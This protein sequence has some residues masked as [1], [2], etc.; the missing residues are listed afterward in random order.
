MNEAVLHMTS[1]SFIAEVAE[2]LLTETL[3]EVDKG[4]AEGP[5][6]S[7]SLE[8]GATVSRRFP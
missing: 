3:L 1:S 8:S 4:W 7:D 5:F 6:S 2:Q